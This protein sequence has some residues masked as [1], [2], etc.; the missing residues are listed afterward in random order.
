MAGPRADDGA[1]ADD[2]T[3]RYAWPA[4]LALAQDLA[5]L[6]ACRGRRVADLGCGRGHCGRSALELGASSVLFLD[7]SAALIED[8][9]QAAASWVIPAGGSPASTGQP[10]QPEQPMSARCA[11]E[12][13]V[14]G[15]VLPG[16]PF[17]LILGGDIL[18]RDAALPALFA[19][20]TCSLAAG[21]LALLSDPRPGLRAHVADAWAACT[22]PASEHW[23]LEETRREQPRAYSLLVI[24]R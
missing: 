20:I 16:P 24:R 22:G 8:L 5:T 14:W 4:G 11:F 1:S 10:E 13:A 9:R 21:G 6:A 18:Y 7:A 15:D 2:S 12:C 17:D 23:Q 3:G 19:T